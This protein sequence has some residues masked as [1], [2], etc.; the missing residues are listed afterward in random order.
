MSKFN[1]SNNK[2]SRGL[3][4]ISIVIIT[5]LFITVSVT[6]AWMFADIYASKVT[7]M[8]GKVDIEA[9][10]KG[11][12]FASIEDTDSSCN[13]VIDLDNY[14]DVLI[15]G[16]PISC[17]VNCKVFRST[18]K[19][20]L[21]TS[22]LLEVTDENGNSTGD[23]DILSVAEDLTNQIYD[24]IEKDND[25]YFHS[26]G[27]FYYVG[28]LYPT[29]TTLEGETLLKEIDVET[30]DVIIPFVDEAIKFPEYVTS[31][32]SG[33]GIKIIIKFQAIQN[34]IPDENGNRIPNTITN[35]QLIFSDFDND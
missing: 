35:S 17:I 26:D 33:L 16:M 13:L 24:I 6:L 29:G 5:M 34:Y 4:S 10:G 20:L 19:P 25:W 23:T 22:L 1:Y 27:F 11:T 21:R 8:S 2:T 14:Y 3:S 30:D 9:V 31:E 15:P 32:Y 28:D 18:T 12:E 7:Q